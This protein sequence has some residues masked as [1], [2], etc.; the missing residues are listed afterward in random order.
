[1]LSLWP[2]HNSGGWSAARGYDAAGGA[3]HNFEPVSNLVQER[4]WLAP[5]QDEVEQR[6]D[7]THKRSV[8]CEARIDV[9][10]HPQ[11]EEERHARR[12]D[13]D[14]GEEGL[15]AKEM[16]HGEDDREDREFRE[17]SAC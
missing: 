7:E 3:P 11:R 9:P 5:R 14:R 17:E 10:A 1:M 13:E 4:L 16:A 15:L 12:G 6:S 2:R 8:K